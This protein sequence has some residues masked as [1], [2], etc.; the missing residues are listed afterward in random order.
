[1]TMDV[2]VT[3][4]IALLVVAGLV[5]IVARRLRLPY[6]VGLVATGLGLSFMGL[7]GGHVLTHDLIFTVILPPLLFE[8]TLGIPWHEFRR[9]A[10]PVIV[11]ATFGVVMA[12]AVVAAGMVYLLAWPLVAALVFGTLIAA[13]DP[14]AVI[15]MFKDNRVSGRVR[16]LVESESLLNDGV[17][18]VL[19]GLV[20][21]WIAG[22]P[23][24]AGGALVDLLVT[25]GGGTLVGLACGAMTVLLAGRVADHLVET[26]L[27]VAA[28]YGSFLVAEHWQMSGVMATLAAG[29]IVKTPGLFRL[30]CHTPSQGGHFLSEFWEFAAF[31]ANSGIFLLIGLA[32]PAK[33]FARLGPGPLIVAAILVLIGRALVVYGLCFPFRSTRWKTTVSQQHVLWWGGLRGALGLALALA[34][35]ERLVYRDEIVTTT[36]AVVVFSIVVQGISMPALLRRVGIIR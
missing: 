10:L 32:V 27:S 18:A 22:K 13:T 5:A 16:V 19:F 29:L 26:S 20:L 14:V 3:R 33:A 9:D 23:L 1:M 30:P 21:A 2:F 15:A 34:L 35:P 25:A 7:D 4:L 11:L 12:A 28:A 31:V 17:A 24:S 8:A 6:T 36:F